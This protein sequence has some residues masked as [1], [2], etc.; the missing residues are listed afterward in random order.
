[1]YR[2]R[3]SW[4]LA[5]VLI[6]VSTPTA[7]P[8]DKV[9]ATTLNDKVLFGYQGWFRTPSDGSPGGWSHWSKGNPTPETMAVD[10]YPDLS[11][12]STKDL[13]Q[14]PGQTI[15]TKPAW[16]F[17]SFNPNVVQKHFEWMKAY[18][19]DGVLLQRFVTD[20]PKVR[21][22]G[23]RVLLNVMHSAEATGRVFAIE[24]DI[25]GADAT[26]VA[27]QLQEDWQHLVNDVHITGSPSYLHDGGHPVVSIWGMGL[28]D[29]SHPP[30]EP[31]P[32]MEVI[33]WF[34]KIAKT[35]VIG[36]TPAY[37]MQLNR[38]AKSDPKWTNAYHQMDV[39]QPWTVGRYGNLEEVD[40]WKA[41]HLVPE[42]IDTA[43]HQQRYMPVIFPGF[44]WH[45]LN[46]Q[47]PANQIPRLGGSFLWRQAINAQSAG[48]KMLKIA[49]FDEVNEGTAMFKAASRR[50]DAPD[51]GYWLTLDA[52][53]LKLPSDWYLRLAGQITNAFHTHK[54]LPADPPKP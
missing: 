49:M 6:G 12:F 25:S 26:K 52:D 27:N 38:D 23:D 47:S 39:I 33:N 34:Q 17:S 10:L 4:L 31:P 7:T 13:F 28:S 37:W 2:D 44:S 45:N 48:A 51:Q 35:M 43:A 29:K 32:A 46:P 5:L 50:I 41:D 15:G 1:M 8:P 18:G 19:L 11:E 16:L 9:D 14:I 30:S 20:I 54:S 22:E 36:G 24:Y 21:S 3:M 40:R 42:L 53:G